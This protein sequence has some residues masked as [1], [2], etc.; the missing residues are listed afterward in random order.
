M[1]SIAGLRSLLDSVH[2]RGSKIRL[3]RVSAVAVRAIPV[4][5]SVG[6]KAP[7]DSIGGNLDLVVANVV[8]VTAAATRELYPDCTG[9]R[10]VEVG[11]ALDGGTAGAAEAF[12]GHLRPAR[13]V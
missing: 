5:A 6:Q 3:L 10:R 4:D 12:A 7:S 1:V 8:V 11:S 2:L 9:T 13:A